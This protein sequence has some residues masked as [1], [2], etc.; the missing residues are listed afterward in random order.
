METGSA[1]QNRFNPWAYIPLL[2]FMQALPV[3]LIQ[4]LS[5]IIF[6]DLGIANEEITRWTSLLN[7]P[8]S[9]QLMLGPFVDL[10]KTKR[11]WIQTGQLVIAAGLGVAAFALKT[12]NAFAFTVFVFAISGVMSALTNIATDGF[13]ILSMSKTQQSQFAG[14]MS[15]C[16]R[17]GRLF[18]GAF[19][20]FAA[21]QFMKLQPVMVSG[22]NMTFVK[23]GQ[24]KES[25]FANLEIR[26]GVITDQDGWAVQ[27]EIKTQPGT[28]ELDVRNNG[29]VFATRPLGT[30]KIGTIDLKGA[31]FQQAGKAESPT[32]NTAW[33]VVMGIAVMVYIGG[34]VA[35]RFNL[36]KLATDPE[37]SSPPGD[38]SRNLVRTLALLSIGVGGYFSGNAIVRLIAHGLW[39]AMD[40]KVPPPD[41]K[42]FEGLQGWMLPTPNRVFQFD[43]GL[44]PAI[45][46]VVQLAVS[47]AVVFW[48]VRTFRRSILG[49]P[50]G[51]ALTSFVKQP[52]FGAIFFFILF[53]R[54]G[55]ALVG[56]ITPLFLKDGLDA[57]GLA[58]SN[59]QIGILSGALG[60]VGIILGGIVGGLVVSKIGL[61]RSFIP[62][63][64]AMHVPNLLYLWASLKTM[65][66]IIQHFSGIGDLN[67]T[68]GVMLFVDQFGYGF[69][70]AGYMVY[71]MWVAQRG[72]FVTSH[73]AIG[74]G[75]GALCIAIAGVLS[76]VLQKNFGYTGTFVAVILMSIPGL[77]SLFWIPLDE[78]HQ[79]IKAELAD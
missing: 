34:H 76:G 33:F 45:V 20:V 61:R 11:W 19:L 37:A 14:I 23:D 3:A 6:K 40:G 72:K 73:Y 60:V 29:D 30:E 75:M 18:V 51:E 65:P 36:P 16:Y 79:K 38:T 54:F 41:T 7:L 27:P 63:A 24:N 44:P 43:T 39:S 35:T 1:S 50:M 59:E 52:G 64:L 48:G 56:K 71:L 42:N 31:E 55:E 66:M 62:L 28:Y 2:Y 4:E 68:L 5:V 32:P 67:L 25:S 26:S 22:A 69:G 74:T 46:E 21:G 9:L 47:A 77:L 70:F 8:W 12:P 58:V 49:S 15:T 78:S 57:G 13:A 10:N 53:Y 17:L